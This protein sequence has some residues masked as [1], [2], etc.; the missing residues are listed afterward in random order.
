MDIKWLGYNSFLI[1][2]K[3]VSVLTDPFGEG[4]EESPKIKEYAKGD[5][6]LKTEDSEYT[7]SEELADEA[8]VFDWPGEYEAKDVI[9]HSVPFGTAEDEKRVITFELDGISF[10]IAGQL[11]KSP[12]DEM[13][14]EL[15]DVDV[16][17]VPLTIKT[18]EAIKLI[19][20]IDPRLV[21]LSM[22]GTQGLP[23]ITDLLKEVGMT[24]LKPED[25]I[26]IKGKSSLD[27]E[28]INYAF[29]SL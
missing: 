8:I 15:G 1:K 10:C 6:V 11:E 17:I 9:I 12:G 4:L 25:K 24:D 28:T 2:G 7:N 23:P 27:S 18:K 20:E 5:I 3:D 26:T 22:F 14:A 29:L 13:I 16:L 19:E 21:V